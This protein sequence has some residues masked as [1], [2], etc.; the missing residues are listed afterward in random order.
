MPR[1][2]QWVE[3]ALSVDGEAAEAV[4]ELLQRYS[5]QGVAIEQEDIPAEAWDDGQAEP[6]R[7]L[8]I[9]AYFP[10]D[11]RVEE[12]KFQLETALGHMSL[13]Y[14]MPTPTYRFINEA[15]WANAWKKNYHPIRLGRRLLIR[16]EWVQME[17]APDDVVITLDPGMA[18]GTGTHPTT[19]LS[20]EA[21]EDLVTPGMQVLDLGCGSGVLSI[22][23][24]H[25]GAAHILALDIDPIAVTATQQNAERNAVSDR[26]HAAEGSLITA[27]E[28]DQQFDLVVANILAHVIIAMSDDGLGRTVRPGGLGVFSGIIADQAAEVESALRRTGLKP[29]ARRQQGDWVAILARR[30]EAQP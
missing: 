19:Q 30:P 5:Y 9:R 17:T 10:A 13:M 4:A 25:L 8:T 16:P 3:V 2:E 1:P 20:L 11:R 15:D 14:P 29:Y 27:L 26:I 22:A 28:T 21:L 18:F 12:T 23:A 24:A 6:P 7:R